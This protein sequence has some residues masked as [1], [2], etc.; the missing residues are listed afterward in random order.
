MLNNV[1][2]EK[3]RRI[4]IY[5]IFN[6]LILKNFNLNNLF[7]TQTS[8]FQLA[9][10]GLILNTF[11]N[12]LKL[13]INGLNSAKNFQAHVN[14]D[15]IGKMPLFSTQL[16][17]R[18]SH[19]TRKNRLNIISFE[20]TIIENYPIKDYFKY[21]IIFRLVMF[22]ILFGFQMKG[23]NLPIF[24]SLLILYYWYKILSL[25]FHI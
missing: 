17:D 9:E 24:I 5:I 6:N 15:H 19:E 21:E 18:I 14:L 7:K 12:L 1:C 20:D 3:Y 25:N 10:K 8:A 13:N 23:Y 11:E 22:F 16:K 4:F 2:V